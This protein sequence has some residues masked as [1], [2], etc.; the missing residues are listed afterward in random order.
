[1]EDMKAI[2]DDDLIEFLESIG[3][4]KKIIRGKIKCKFCGEIITID[5]ISNIF[6][7]SGTV[8]Y[9]CNNPN[10][11]VQFNKKRES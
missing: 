4:Y 9:I 11:I 3:E 2:Y 7:E 8:K 5:N 1:M 10:C 6:P